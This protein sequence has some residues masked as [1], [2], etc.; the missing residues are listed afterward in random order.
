[1]YIPPGAET[2]SGY[3]I[4]IIKNIRKVQFRLT[5]PKEI[6]INTTGCNPQKLKS[7]NNITVFSMLLRATQEC[8]RNS[9][10]K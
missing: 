4:V 3:V 6:I 8:N 2:R 9:V 1:M 10:F 7:G 5:E